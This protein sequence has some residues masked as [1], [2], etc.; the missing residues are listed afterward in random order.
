MLQFGHYADCT[1]RSIINQVNNSCTNEST[2]TVKSA[3]QC[4]HSH[5]DILSFLSQSLAA[6][7]FS[8]FVVTRI[9]LVETE[10]LTLP[11]KQFFA[12]LLP[13]GRTKGEDQIFGATAEGRWVAVE[14]LVR[15]ITT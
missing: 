12:S 9:S 6:R 3:S 13:L 14:I 8:P 4:I 5:L 10:I 1:P 11:S 7:F 2:T 15:S